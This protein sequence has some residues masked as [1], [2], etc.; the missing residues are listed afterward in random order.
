MLHETLTLEYLLDEVVSRAYSFK[1][2]IQKLEPIVIHNIIEILS[3]TSYQHLK[4]TGTVYNG[5]E[6]IDI[7]A[8]EVN[9]Y[10]MFPEWFAETFTNNDDFKNVDHL[11]RIYLEVTGHFE[12]IYFHDSFIF[13]NKK[14]RIC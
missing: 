6:A 3:K 4:I 9:C 14:L 12:T 1:C 10:T 13:T 2:G 8:T 7:P 11:N 5:L